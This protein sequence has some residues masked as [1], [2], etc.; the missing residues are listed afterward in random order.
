MTTVEALREI[1]KTLGGTGTDITDVM[2]IPDALIKVNTQL[3]LFKSASTLPAVT[4][5]QN[6]KIMKVVEG[7][8]ALA[9]DAIEA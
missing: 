7:A 9:N 1:Y 4:T 6:G 2:T 3:A 8:W 5:T